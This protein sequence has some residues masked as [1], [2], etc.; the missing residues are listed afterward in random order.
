M[1]SAI[2]F[3][4][5]NCYEFPADFHEIIALKK[6]QQIYRHIPG[7][8]CNSPWPRRSW[9]PY[10]QTS[11][12][13]AVAYEWFTSYDPLFAIRS[14][15]LCGRAKSDY[16]SLDRSYDVRYQT[17]SWGG[18]FWLRS[19]SNPSRKKASGARYSG[20]SATRSFA[21]SGPRAARSLLKAS[22][23]EACA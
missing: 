1:T 19:H 23:A 10:P 14:F 2:H 21:A 20:N 8:I 13:Q 11:R 3:K 7:S 6:P 17:S 5:L 22:F 9:W 18:A 16:K 4:K 15:A 12:N